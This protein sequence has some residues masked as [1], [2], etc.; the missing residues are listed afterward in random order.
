MGNLVEFLPPKKVAPTG[1]RNP[2]NSP[3]EVGIAD[4]I[5]SRVSYMSGGDRQISEPSTTYGK[6]LTFASMAKPPIH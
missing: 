2:A 4:P 5:S 6:S 3:V 1:R